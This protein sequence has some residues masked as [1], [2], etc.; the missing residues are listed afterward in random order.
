MTRVRTLLVP[1]LLLASFVAC[2]GDDDGD[3]AAEDSTTTAAPAGQA[4]VDIEMKDYAYAV[5]GTMLEGGTIRAKNT[6]KE[7]HMITVSKFKPGKTLTDLVAAF[8]GGGDEATTTSVLSG[9][10][11]SSTAAGGAENDGEEDDPT[12]DVVDEVDAQGGAGIFQPNAPAVELTGGGLEAGDYALMCF[13]NVEGEDTPHAAKG[14]VGTLKVVKGTTPPPPTADATYKFEKGKAVSGPA[15]LTAGR[16]VLKFEATGANAGDLEATLFK[17]NP[18]KTFADADKL[19]DG[20][21]E[22]LPKNAVSQIPGLIAVALFDFGKQTTLYVAT[23][24]TPGTYTLVG[25]DTDEKDAPSNPKEQISIKV[26]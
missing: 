11:T 24:F 16:H 20:W 22:G 12:S 10:G 8:Q 17:P 5:N 25:Q 15:T 26:A 1:L 3:D 23:D 18:G 4:V 13:I 7:L 6:G 14:M 9:R 19:F 21:E 2:G